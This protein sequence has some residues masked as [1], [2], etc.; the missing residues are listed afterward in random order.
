[1]DVL[2][3]D[4]PPGGGGKIGTP[5]SDLSSKAFGD[6]EPV[7]SDSHTSVHSKPQGSQHISYVFSTD[8]RRPEALLPP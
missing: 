4:I 8:W 2:D 6:C 1:I 3:S 5:F 7:S